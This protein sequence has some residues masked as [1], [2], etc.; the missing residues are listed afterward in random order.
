LAS[1]FFTDGAA[2]GLTLI[3][4]TDKGAV[5]ADPGNHPA[6]LFWSGYE[7]TMTNQ[8][9][10]CMGCTSWPGARTSNQDAIQ[11]MHAQNG[12]AILAHPTWPGP[13]S[14]IDTDVPGLSA[15]DGIEVANGQ[16]FIGFN[17]W[18]SLL[19]K[20]R[21]VIGTGGNDLY[22]CGFAE[23]LWINS[24]TGNMADLIANFKL[25]NFYGSDVCASVAQGC[26]PGHAYALR[27]TQNGNTLTA[28]FQYSESDSTIV[29]TQYIRWKCGYPTAGSTCG[30]GASYTITGNE[31][32]VRPSYGVED[33]GPMRAWGNPIYVVPNRV[34]PSAAS[35][36]SVSAG[37]A[38]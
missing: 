22:A 13:S 38:R 31:I 25:G 10:V 1:Q 2:N 16:G 28:R 18:D 12:I 9:M 20:G 6:Q 17:L 33:Y 26:T 29:D 5:T 34:S 4:I 19:F 37:V 14:W 35:S 27:V 7:E 11:K 8:H 32:Y 23:V 36:T 3:P 30:A 21:R 24:P 15:I